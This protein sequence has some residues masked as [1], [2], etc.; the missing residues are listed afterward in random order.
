MPGGIL[1]FTT[2]YA[3]GL[4]HVEAK[5]VPYVLQ[6]NR[7]PPTSNTGLERVEAEDV[8][9]ILQKNTQPPVSKTH[10]A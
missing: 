2:A 7:Q 3:T 10:A 9:Y 6:K 4:E 5:D 8:L 1:L